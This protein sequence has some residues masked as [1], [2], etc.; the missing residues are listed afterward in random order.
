[1]TKHFE[2]GKNW[3][4]YS[5]D[6]ND[7]R[8]TIAEESLKEM[9]GANNISGK[10]FLDIGCGSGLFSLAAVRLG[11]KNV[12]SFDYDDDS[13]KISTVLKEKY[14]CNTN[15]W[16]I[17][18][19]DVLD[20]NYLGKLG[21]YGIVYSWGVLHHTGDMWQALENVTVNVADG[22][23]ICIAIYN[24]QGKSSKYWRMVKKIYNVLPG[25][26]KWLILIPAFGRVWFPSFIKDFLKFG[27]PLATWNLYWQERGMSPWNDFIDWIGGYPFE[28]A[29]PE[30]VLEFFKRKGFVLK[31]SKIC[32]GYGC[33]EFVFTKNEY[34]K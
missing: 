20:L 8:I 26:T 12:F 23:S 4:D 27:Q 30:K 29:K 2:F 17:E 11:A 7:I 19:G 14:A 24:D 3:K 33:N 5:S 18:H 28:V 10:T 1:M 34:E 31:K 16:K 6:I 21:K 22:G 13:V 15:T 25:V 9:L 32:S